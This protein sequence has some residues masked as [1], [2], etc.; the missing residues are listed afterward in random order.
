MIRKRLVIS[1]KVQGVGFRFFVKFKSSS[2]NIT[3]F[4]RNLDNSDVLVELQGDENSID[5][6]I[7]I[8][9]AGNGF[10]RVEKIVQSDIDL[11]PSESYFN[12][13]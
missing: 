5:K 10:C 9:Y 13:Y 11:V 2:F 12:M 7:K 1:G 3:G 8:L 6:V 4:A